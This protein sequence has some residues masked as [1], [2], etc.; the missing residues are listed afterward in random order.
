MAN[1]T[2][3]ILPIPG[4][5]SGDKETGVKKPATSMRLFSFSNQFIVWARH[6][7]YGDAIKVYVDVCSNTVSEKFYFCRKLELGIPKFFPSHFVGSRNSEIRTR[8]CRKSESEFRYIPDLFC[9]TR[10]CLRPSSPSFGILKNC[11]IL[12]SDLRF[13]IYFGVGQNVLYRAI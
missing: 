8:K 2:R 11:D 12:L 10:R 5:G 1:S 13:S 4:K 3:I 6:C 7:M 9:L